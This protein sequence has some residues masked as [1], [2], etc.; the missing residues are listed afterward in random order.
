MS[1]SS[2]A[3][4]RLSA[5]S[6]ASPYPSQ[7]VSTSNYKNP[8][9]Y[10]SGGISSA[11]TTSSSYQ[12]QHAPEY[13]WKLNTVSTGGREYLLDTV[14]NFVYIQP[15]PSDWI[16][17]V[18]R[19]DPGTGQLRVE[20][21]RDE[22]GLFAELD[23]YL[24]STQTKFKDMFSSFAVNNRGSLDIHGLARLL[25]QVRPNITDGEIYYFQVMLDVDGDGQIEYDEFMETVKV[26]L[27]AEKG[28]AGGMSART[29]SV[30]DS[31]ADKLG[32]TVSSTKRV[33]DD[34]DY[35]TGR[36]GFL[37]FPDFARFLSKVMPNLQ[38]ADKRSI[39][40]YLNSLDL[41]HTG[42]IS[43]TQLMR[44]MSKAP[45][46][47]VSPAVAVTPASQSR[48]EFE[49]KL[50]PVSTGGRE[51]LLDM[52]TN[53]VYFQPRPTEW[54]KA[55]GKKDPYSGQLKVEEQRDEKGLFAEL[56]QYL[57]NTQT[58]FKDMFS[59][60]AVNN[61]DSLDIHGLARLLRKV[62]PNITDGEIY[63]FQVMLDVDGDGQIE[64]DEF[65]ETVKV[66]LAVEKGEAGGM[67]ARTRSVMDSL[68][69]TL[70]NSVRTANQVFNDL[71]AG[72]K[73]SLAF[74]DFARFLSKVM[75]NLQAADKRS[76][77]AYL[78]SLDLNHTGHISFTQL[79]R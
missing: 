1:Y 78:N 60:F 34:L 14:T 6:A 62:Q 2:A 16:K 56:D 67:S 10:A 22:K 11:Y 57:K 32:S 39:V 18:G 4:S 31:L 17:A 59:S 9:V 79:M 63:Y 43:F 64:Y 74:P 30:M 19:K 71:D 47:S 26:S 51:Y 24:K 23:Q 75:P 40:A 12:Q 72:R 55:V 44:Y 25:R 8:T 13:E 15:R 58:K 33:F 52:E 36:K 53:F 48:S 49:W 46:G 61:R 70:F 45:A 20:E 42:H 76:I 73:G 41:N 21:Q 27:A 29:R 7:P 69:S 28:E 38:A 66:S 35:E 77:V 65:M 50:S 54:L 3:P 5:S 37:V 68:A